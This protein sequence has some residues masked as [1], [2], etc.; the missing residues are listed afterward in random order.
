MKHPKC[1]TCGER[2]R[3]G[4]CPRKVIEHEAKPLIVGL[5]G[6]AL[7]DEIARSVGQTRRGETPCVKATLATNKAA[8]SVGDAVVAEHVKTV[9]LRRHD[10]GP[11]DERHPPPLGTDEDGSMAKITVRLPVSL[12]ARVDSLAAAAARGGSR[13]RA[14]RHLILIGLKGEQP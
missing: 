9:K 6:P 11:L 10:L 2:H 4:P 8:M 1:R 14:I 12:I 3:L 13:S 7:A 5:V